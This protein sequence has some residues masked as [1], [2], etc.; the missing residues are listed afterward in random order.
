MRYSRNGKSWITLRG[1][2]YHENFSVNG[3]RFRGSLILTARTPLNSLRRK[4]RSDALLGN[5]VAQKRE[6]TV[7][8]APRGFPV[9]DQTATA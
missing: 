7:H 2:I 1:N 5:L 4:K 9:R 8:A 6:I 3:H